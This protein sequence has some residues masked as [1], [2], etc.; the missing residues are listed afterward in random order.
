MKFEADYDYVQ[1]NEQFQEVLSQ[2]S[3]TKIDDPTAEVTAAESIENGEEPVDNVDVNVEPE[4][5]E[6][7]EDEEEEVFYDK[8]KSFFDSISCE[9]LERSKGKMVRNDWRAEKRLNKETFGVAGNR[10][11]GYGGRGGYYNNRGGRGFNN[12]G[13]QGYNRGGGYGRGG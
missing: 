8:Q 2:L 6:I 7:N 4:E 1:A 10:R 11:Y 3:K 13:G 5:G 9:A 12:Q